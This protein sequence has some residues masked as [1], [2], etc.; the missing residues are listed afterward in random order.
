MDW[1]GAGINGPL[2][3][4]RAIHFAATAVT[5]GTLLFRAVVAEP[6]LASAQ[7]A[8]AVIRLQ[9]TPVAWTGFTIAAATG[10]IWLLL[11]AASMSG[12]P[13]IEAMNSDV[14]STVL[15]ETQFGRVAKIRFVLAIIL[16]ACLAYDRFALP[17]RLALGAAV[18][19]IAAIAWTG[20][21]ASTPGVTG[22]LHLA[23]DALHLLGRAYKLA[24]QER[25]VG[26]LYAQANLQAGN[27]VRATALLEPFAAS[28]NDAAGDCHQNTTT[29]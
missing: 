9:I 29:N 18:G 22:V 10:V 14:L 27:A 2:V 28:E 6:A 19:L 4:V 3:V 7:M 8:P 16:A 15:N 24:P 13:F 26:L 11:Q 20:H 25:S 5:A 1:F 12:L 23:A 21:A 17:R